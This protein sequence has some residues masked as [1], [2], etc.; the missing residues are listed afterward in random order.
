VVGQSDTIRL[1]AQ[2]QRAAARMV[3]ECQRCSQNANAPACASPADQA[4]V[5]TLEISRDQ[6][7]RIY[8][9]QFPLPVCRLTGKV[10]EAPKSGSAVKS[11]I[12]RRKSPCIYRRTRRGNL[13]YWTNDGGL[14]D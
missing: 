7:R 9:S 1:M 5:P 4:Q 12:T 8:V 10:I 14:G 2:A 13:K 6:R 3:S 11:Q